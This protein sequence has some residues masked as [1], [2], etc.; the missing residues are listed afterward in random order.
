M[1]AGGF[2]NYSFRGNTLVAGGAAPLPSMAGAACSNDLAGIEF[3][4]GI[5]GTAGGPSA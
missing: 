5:P 3:A 1:L 4:V 2:R